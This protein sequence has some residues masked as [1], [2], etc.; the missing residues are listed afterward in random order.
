[1]ET[2][3]SPWVPFR[4]KFWPLS[5]SLNLQHECLAK[6]EKEMES[7]AI[8]NELTVLTFVIETGLR[9][10]NLFSCLTQLSIKSIL[11]TNI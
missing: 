5:Y 2:P 11:L 6:S 3:T 7:K 1:M 10:I 8:A 4:A 9:V